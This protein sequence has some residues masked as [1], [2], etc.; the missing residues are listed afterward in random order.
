MK[1]TKLTT[2]RGTSKNVPP[3]QVESVL[4][5]PENNRIPQNSYKWYLN[6]L[7]FISCGLFFAWVVGLVT[8]PLGAQRFIFNDGAD[9]VFGDFY[10]LLHIIAG[11]DPYSDPH[12]GNYFPLAY[13]I[14]YPCS[15]LD[16]FAAMS[17][18][19]AR[20]SAMWLISSFVFTGFSVFLLFA[21]LSQLLKKY[22]ISPIIL[23]SLALSFAFIFTI[24]RGNFIIISAACVCFFICNY[25]SENKYKRILS[26]IFLAIA[27]TLKIYP[28]LFGLLYLEK[29]HYQKLL[30]CATVTIILVFIPYL[31]FKG[32]FANIPQHI[33]NLAMGYAGTDHIIYPLF[34]LPRSLYF[35]L[36]NILEFPEKTILSLLN[37]AKAVN[38]VVCIVALIFSCLIENRWLKM[39]LITMAILYLPAYSGYYCGIYMFPMI[40]LF[41]PTMRERTKFFNIFI[42]IIF[43]AFL[44]PFQIALVEN[45]RGGRIPVTSVNYIMVNIL[46]Y[47]FL[48]VLLI[49]SGK[50]IA[51]K[52]LRRNVCAQNQK[53]QARSA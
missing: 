6:M 45:N 24:E 43:I 23:V 41:Y 48:L 14:L 1:K 50:Q 18:W 32:G 42:F 2:T 15:L 52:L 10:E 13:V 38:T 40:I 8:N 5:S 33:K 26:A 34:S 27:I 39:S 47:I 36:H 29:K 25:D 9:R 3:L 12:Y 30:F 44:N 21:T 17:V 22:S 49:S 31:F 4:I 51:M 11:R 20:G 46:L 16:N 35:C 19:E 7:V 28:V 37:A 53:E